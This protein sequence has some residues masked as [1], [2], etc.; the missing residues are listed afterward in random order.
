LNTVLFGGPL[1]NG[2]DYWVR[3]SSRARFARGVGCSGQ[4]YY[5]TLLLGGGALYRGRRP[6]LLM[7][8]GDRVAARVPHARSPCSVGCSRQSS[9]SST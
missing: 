3:A 1:R 8:C 4:R 7:A 9:S 6:S 5:G 2:Y